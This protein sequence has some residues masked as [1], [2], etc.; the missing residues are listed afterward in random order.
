MLAKRN[1]KIRFMEFSPRLYDREPLCRCCLDECRAACCLY[2]VWLD[3]KE[4]DD[5]LAH[6]ALI[7]PL[8]R[9]GYADP[10]LW[11]NDEY[12]D[13]EFTPSQKVRHSA[14]LSDRDHYG[15]T[16]CVFLRDDFKCA[17]Q[18]AADQNGFH[19]W[20]FKPFYCVLHPLD[21]DENGRITL[22]ETQ[23]LLEEH[24]SCL[25]STSFRIPLAET[26]APELTYFLGIETQQQILNRSKS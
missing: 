9:P 2:G 10:V 20:R 7:S 11:F 6:S 15:E 18:V 24:G 25:R 5:I 14:V 13:D 16:S 22:D 23:L 21:L 1:D 8:M 12:D 3:L 17:L 4:V 26:F 19:S